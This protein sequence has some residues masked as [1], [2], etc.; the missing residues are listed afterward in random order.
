MPRILYE[1]PARLRK[2]GSWTQLRP[3]VLFISTS[4]HEMDTG[5]RLDVENVGSVLK[6]LPCVCA[7]PGSSA[8]CGWYEEEGERLYRHSTRRKSS[9]AP[10]R[11]SVAYTQGRRQELPSGSTPFVH[12]QDTRK[13]IEEY[14]VSRQG[15]AMEEYRVSRHGTAME[16]YRVSR[17][18]SPMELVRV[19]TPMVEKKPVPRVVEVSRTPR[20]PEKRTTQFL[21]PNI[22][23]F[24]VFSEEPTPSSR[25]SSQNHSQHKKRQVGEVKQKT[26]GFPTRN[27]P[28]GGERLSAAPASPR[29]QTA[30]A[31]GRHSTQSEPTNGGICPPRWR[32][33]YLNFKDMHSRPS[34]KS[35]YH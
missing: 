11:R 27:L 23:T 25:H 5:R 1:Q 6:P 22:V 28:K 9:V 32:P 31:S 7:S 13:Y 24:Q 19:T 2:H 33:Q 26:D 3:R 8:M 15:S 21:P 29:S 16:E 4:F 35:F 12:H 10:R 20:P 18:R 30:R 34:C 17:Q 14:R